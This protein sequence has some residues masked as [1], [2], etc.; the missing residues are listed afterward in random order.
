M[1]EV[2]V[3]ASI[4]L[5]SEQGKMCVQAGRRSRVV[6]KIMSVALPLSM[7]TLF[8]RL[9]AT[10]ALSTITSLCGC[11]TRLASL[12]VKYIVSEAW[13]EVLYT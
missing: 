8:T 12:L 6:L 7:R 9:L 4:A 10:W 13:T 3:I 5:A 2:H 1:G 11:T